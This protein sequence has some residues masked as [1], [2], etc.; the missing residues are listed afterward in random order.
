MTSSKTHLKYL[1]FIIIA[2]LS[3]GIGYATIN[4][5]NL[6]IAGTAALA[7]NGDVTIS[8]ASLSSY[9]NVVT[10]NPTI[11]SDHNAI[12]FNISMTVE[13]AEDLEADHY[14]RYQITIENDSLYPYQ[15]TPDTF[16]ATISTGNANDINIT[17]TIEDANGNQAI[18]ATIPKKSSSTFY[19][20]INLYPQNKG[21]WSVNGD[22]GITTEPEVTG[23]LLA[24][25]PSNQS[26]D[27][28]GSN[29]RAH[30][31]VDVLNSYETDQTFTLTTD[32]TVFKLVDQNGNNLTTMTALAS[33]TASFDFYVEKIGNPKFTTDSQAINISFNSRNIGAVTVA[34]DKDTTIIDF[35]PPVISNVTA[36]ITTTEGTIT[37][38]WSG[39][40]AQSGVNHYVIETYQ[41]NE[42]ETNPTLI[43]TNTSN[44]TSYNATVTADGYYFFKVYGVDNYTPSNTANANQIS[45]C[46]TSSG[47]CSR[48]ANKNFVW[49]FTVTFSL[50][51]ATSSEGNSVAVKYGG[52]VTSTLTGTMGRP[53]IDGVTMTDAAGTN[54]TVTTNS[55]P[56]K[57]STANNGNTGLNITISNIIGNVT[58]NASAQCLTEGT[59][60][61]LANGK[62]KKVEN[63]GYD[64]LLAVWNYDTG[65][66]T[67]EYPLWI[68]NS[69][70]VNEYKKITFSDDSYINIVGNHGFYS[71]D[72]NL[73]INLSDPDFKIGTNLARISNN[74]EFSSV[75]IK[76]IEKIK[77]EIRYYFIGTTT[78]YNVIANNMLTT[79]RNVII[80]NLYGFED[81]AKWPKLKEEI[82][83]KKE[84]ILDYSYFKDVLPHY[85][86]KG[87]R[88]G[89]SGFL[90]N[91]NVFTLEE[92]KYYI[93]SLIINPNMLKKPI[94]ENG[95]NKWMVTTS[96]DNVTDS[97][98]N[99]FLKFEGS[100]YTLPKLKNITGWYNTADNK[101]YK[102]GSKIRV[103][104]GLHFIG[105]K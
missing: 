59:D 80:S 58:V 87:F 12:N 8:A 104:H 30:F 77:K 46:S 16:N 103:D 29:T 56:T 53:S 24:S 67:Y 34:V 85:L 70:A 44:T 18:N 78:Y 47:A 64:D 74:G 35:D 2:I 21:N 48:S 11:N 4:N 50:D 49:N 13:T 68:E 72:K 98:K 22:S 86:Y 97:N 45:S 52:S 40:D 43:A 82:V 10:S 60:I 69:Y 1:I 100:Y 54:Y 102:P 6:T 61:L 20:V 71:T 19:V 37:V 63:I 3:M 14:A 36:N 28:T 55:T 95:K 9:L 94:Q 23:S 31:T 83:S 27:L 39:Q 42:N 99:T 51:N 38:S 75:S 76:K 41:S 91:N 101:I 5:I 79:D 88:A 25:L 105:V 33:T 90:I 57:Y 84:N 66:L 89:E 92:F 62:T 96:E 81:N 7:N 73:F 17:S 65:S 26:G 32:S 15:V 93:T